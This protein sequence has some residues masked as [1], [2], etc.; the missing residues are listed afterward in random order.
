MDAVHMR[1]ALAL[2]KRAWG[3]TSPNPMVGAVLFKR[4]KVIGEGWHRRAGMAHAEVEAL[5]A[6]VSG[7]GNP[8]GATLYVTLEPC[9]THGRTPP[10]T[11][12]ILGAGVRRVVVGAVDPNPAHA[13]K[14]LEILR[15]QGVDVAVEP[16]GGACEELNEPFNHWIVHRSPWVLLKS[17][18]TLDGKIATA[19]GLSKWITSPASRQRAM[20]WRARVDAILVGIS[21]VELDDPSLTVRTR[22]GRESARQPMRV[23][24]D[25]HARTPV[26]CR[27]TSDAWR[28]RTVVFVGPAV[29]ENRVRQLTSQV[30]VRQ[31]PVVGGGLDLN[32]VMAELSGL[33]VT[34]L[35][36]EGGGEVHA[37]FLRAGLVH[38][39]LFFYAPKILG[40]GEARRAVGGIGAGAWAEVL[41][42]VKPEWHSSGEDLCVSARVK[43]VETGGLA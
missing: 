17:G 32:A 27:L 4:G 15:Q 35:L 28:S 36:V 18:M 3:R 14:G 23:V 20:R 25:T 22:G 19:A 37:S 12:A 29:P 10:C 34:S 6:A 38:R 41:R 8:S 26:G 9:C 2:A 42:L 33:G 21:T 5:N 11:N 40:G 30:T 31:V 13:G 7:G 1:R 43:G 39:V 16:L 24:L